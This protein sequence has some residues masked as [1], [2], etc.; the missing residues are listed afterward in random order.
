MR[1]SEK[2]RG[3]CWAWLASRPNSV[4]KWSFSLHLR[5]LLFCLV[6]LGPPPQGGKKAANSPG[7]LH[8][9]PSYLSGKREPLIPSLPSHPKLGLKDLD[10]VPYLS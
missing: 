10:R 9:L 4:H 3:I 8:Y 6:T 7:P 2:G 1:V 5:A